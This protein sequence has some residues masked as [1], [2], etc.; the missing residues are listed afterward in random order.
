MKN[1][2]KSI[3]VLLICVS[4]NSEAK[5]TLT[6]LPNEIENIQENNEPSEGQ[7]VAEKLS[8]MTPF[9]EDALRKA[10]P[11]QLKELS[12]D[13]KITVIGQQIIGR[14]GDGKISLSIADAAGDA[15]QLAQQMID[16]YAFNQHQENEHF[17][18]IKQE[19]NGMETLT[20][21]Y[22]TNGESE[23]RFL[24]NKRFYITFSNDDNMIK[25]NPDELW[26]A[27]DINTLN[28]YKEMNK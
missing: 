13:D 14:F 5:K 22:K 8:K 4:C 27:F 28:G 2:I 20:D 11:K 21:Y 1:V 16:S 24:Y 10:F 12:V 6:E 9:S 26:E 25:M 19:R 17:K 3:L 18:V 15:N 23:V 7:K